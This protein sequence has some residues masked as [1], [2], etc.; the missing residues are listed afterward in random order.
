MVDMAGDDVPAARS[1]VN[2]KGGKVAAMISRSGL[3]PLLHEFDLTFCVL[4]GNECY[5]G[6][7]SLHCS[8]F[9]FCTYC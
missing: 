4:N 6:K 9:L 3:Y 2:S 1:I 7:L 5:D 8:R